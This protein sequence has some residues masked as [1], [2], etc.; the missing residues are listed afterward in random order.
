MVWVQELDALDDLY[1]RVFGHFSTPKSDHGLLKKESA[2]HGDC[3]NGTR[4]TDEILK[5]RPFPH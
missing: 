5:L 2:A 1:F 3:G 4:S